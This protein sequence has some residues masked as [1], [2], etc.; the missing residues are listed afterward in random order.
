M[1]SRRMVL[2]F[3]SHLSYDL[4]VSLSVC[5]P[6]SSSWTLSNTPPVYVCVTDFASLSS[7]GSSTLDMRLWFCA[8]SA[9]I[10]VSP[11]RLLSY[12]HLLFCKVPSLE[13][14]RVYPHLCHC[15][16][17]LLFYTVPPLLYVSSPSLLSLF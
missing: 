15:P 9:N 13:P 3:M 16:L 6:V 2:I 11:L 10:P 5:F 1:S 4:S 17:C 7:L 8:V 12:F 14:Q